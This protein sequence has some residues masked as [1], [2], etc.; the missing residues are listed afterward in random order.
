MTAVVAQPQLKDYLKYV[1]FLNVPA[2]EL[3]HRIETRRCGQ[4]LGSFETRAKAEAFLLS[5]DINR[6]IRKPMRKSNR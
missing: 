5:Y 3:P 6:L 2:S 1:K 4:I